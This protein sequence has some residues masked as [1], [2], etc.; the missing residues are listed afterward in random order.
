MIPTAF[1]HVYTERGAYCIEKR[2]STEK[3]R[4]DTRSADR[5]SASLRYE[6]LNFKCCTLSVI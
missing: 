5:A 6:L 1:V 4:S 3:Y 2:S